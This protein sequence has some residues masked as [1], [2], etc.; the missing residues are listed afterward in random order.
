MARTIQPFLFIFNP[1]RHLTHPSHAA[2]VPQHSLD[3]RRLRVLAGIFNYPTLEWHSDSLRIQFRP[4]K[5]FQC[6]AGIGIRDTFWNQELW[7]FT[8]Y[9]SCTNVSRH[10]SCVRLTVISLTISISLQG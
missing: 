7:R 3:I 10:V 6:R 9:G 4:Q 2:R 5:V 1:P 8:R